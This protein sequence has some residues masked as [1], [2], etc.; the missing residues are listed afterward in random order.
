MPDSSSATPPPA[1]PD[2]ALERLVIG[3]QRFRSGDSAPRDEQAEVATT[4]AAQQPFATVLACVD[5]RVTPQ[6]IFDQ[7][8]GDI[9]GVRVAGNTV[10]DA[11]LAS[12]EF[13]CEAFGTPC[14]VVLGHTRCG[15]VARVTEGGQVGHQ[16]GPTDKLRR[17]VDA[18]SSVDGGASAHDE[19]TTEVARKN[20]ALTVA[21][22]RDESP[23]LAALEQQGGLLITG[24]LYDVATGAVV[25]LP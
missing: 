23:V 19:F 13:A 10:S 20:V 9:V 1:T 15:A 5:S 24:A 8:L 6:R 11:V 12:L 25:F 22:I 17:A 7:G 18:T 4:S 16:P 21:D 2:Q 14:L 3:N